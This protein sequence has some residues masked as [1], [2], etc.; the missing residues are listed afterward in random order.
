MCV[1]GSVFTLFPSFNNQRVVGFSVVTSD[2]DNDGSTITN[3]RNIVPIVDC[4]YCENTTPI[5]NTDT[6]KV[7]IGPGSTTAIKV[8]DLM[9]TAYFEMDGN[10][11][12]LGNYTVSVTDPDPLPEWITFDG[13]SFTVTSDSVID[14]PVTQDVTISVTISG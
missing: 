9:S 7:T 6:L 1:G 10:S 2:Y 12:C 5:I 14:E 3:I 4:P 11:Y 13:A 8:T